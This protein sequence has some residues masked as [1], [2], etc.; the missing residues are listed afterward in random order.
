MQ[1]HSKLITEA[2]KHH[3][4]P[5]GAYQKGRSRIWLTDN[6][7][8]LCVIEFQPSSWG[9]G[10]YLNVGAHFLWQQTDGI[11]FDF[12][13]RKEEFADFRNEAQFAAEADKLAKRAAEELTILRQRLPHPTAVHSLSPRNTGQA[14]IDR[15]HRGISHALDGQVDKAIFIFESLVNPVSTEWIDPRVE[16]YAQLLA[17]LHDLDDFKHRITEMIHKQREALRLPVIEDPLSFSAEIENNKP[18]NS[19][20]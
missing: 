5:L 20:H 9:K 15:Y 10:S 12:G 13:Y 14:W 7:W 19:P 8:H 6:G 1:I 17:L 2:A 16:T 4:K 3:L 11:T 18:G